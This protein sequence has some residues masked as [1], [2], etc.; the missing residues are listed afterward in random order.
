MKKEIHLASLAEFLRWMTFAIS[1]C[2]IF[3]GPFVALTFAK[4]PHEDKLYPLWVNDLFS[5]FPYLVN[6]YA[7]KI[8]RLDE[9]VFADGVNVFELIPASDRQINP[10]IAIDLLGL[11]LENPKAGGFSSLRWTF[12]NLV[13]KK[14][15]FVEYAVEKIRWQPI[16]RYQSERILSEKRLAY[17]QY[18]NQAK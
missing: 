9:K 2:A 1:V 10:S 17:F 18:S 3:V 4:Y 7:I 8:Y 5:K 13:F 14:F 16:S 15:H 11:E 12:E 6:G